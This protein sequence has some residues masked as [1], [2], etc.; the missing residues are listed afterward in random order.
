M[1]ASSLLYYSV[2]IST[3]LGQFNHSGTFLNKPLNLEL[4]RNNLYN[5]GPNQVSPIHFYPLKE[6]I[7]VYIAAKMAKNTWSQSIHYKEVSL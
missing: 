1:F 2:A 7:S 3:Y 5:I 6:E 4:N